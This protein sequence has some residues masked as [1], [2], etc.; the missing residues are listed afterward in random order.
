[1]KSGG[2]S[3]DGNGFIAINPD[4][5]KRW[6]YANGSN[7]LMRPAIGADGT[8]YVASW[9]DNI[10][11]LDITD[12]SLKWSRATGN[13]IECHPLIGADGTLYFGSNDGNLY[14]IKDL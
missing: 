4:G 7:I 5:T 10:R 12:G 9:D 1:V 14:A 11:A 3:A 13:W 2:G 8:V 6:H